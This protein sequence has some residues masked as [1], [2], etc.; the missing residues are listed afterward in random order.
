MP[1]GIPTR[2]PAL[3]WSL[4][5]LPLGLATGC[6]GLPV[7]RPQPAAEPQAPAQAA[8]DP[9]DWQPQ[10]AATAAPPPTFALASRGAAPSQPTPLLDAALERSHAQK[11][12]VL[13][14]VR[15]AAPP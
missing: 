8:L 3:A 9:A 12:A 7:R 14:D 1:L 6:Q 5:L 15:P 13:S 10:P 2:V 4:L 11:Q